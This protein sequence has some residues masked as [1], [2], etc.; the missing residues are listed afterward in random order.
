MAA[1]GGGEGGG[2]LGD[3]GVQGVLL[4]AK[5]RIHNDASHDD[6]RSARYW[7]TVTTTKQRAQPPAATL[8]ARLRWNSS[9]ERAGIASSLLGAP[10][11]A[12][13]LSAGAAAAAMGA[14]RL[15]AAGADAMVATC[16]AALGAARTTVA[17]AA[18][19]VEGEHHSRAAG[20]HR[21]PGQ[22]VELAPRRQLERL[23]QDLDRPLQR[24]RAE[25]V[26]VREDEH[27]LRS[28]GTEERGEAGQ[29]CRSTR[30]ARGQ[31]SASADRWVPGS[32][33]GR[34]QVAVLCCTA[35][36]PT[37]SE[38]PLSHTR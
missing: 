16:G 10:T 5:S 30:R 28:V 11:V 4:G 25:P 15:P 14:G 24:G 35:L 18:G 21:R 2:G 20:K 12:S 3:G 36:R 6:A 8:V 37:A 7:P 9:N 26:K 31:P 23:A 17:A 27:A 38:W 13:G 32:K 29:V 1:A 33:G 19:E 22:L 34:S